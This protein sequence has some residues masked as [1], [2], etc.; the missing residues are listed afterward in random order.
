Q[1]SRDGWGACVVCPAGTYAVSNNTGCADCPTGFTSPGGSI[2]PAD[3]ILPSKVIAAGGSLRLIAGGDRH[4]CAVLN[5][6]YVK[7]WGLNN[8]GQLGLGDSENRGDTDD[9]GEN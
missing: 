8:N 2:S 3:C 6:G 1:Y 4:S 9:M 5:H 7:C